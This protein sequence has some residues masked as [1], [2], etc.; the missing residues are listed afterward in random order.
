MAKHRDHKQQDGDFN[1]ISDKVVQY[2]SRIGAQG[3]TEVSAANLASLQKAHMMS[4]PYENYDIWASKPSS[5]AY[6]V[7]F[8]KIVVRRRGGYC[9]ELNGLFG[10][11]LRELGYEVEEYFGRWLKDE[12]LKIPA[13]RHRIL[14]VAVEGREFIVD[15]GVGQRTFLTPLE[16]VYD[17]VQNREGVDYRIVKNE[18]EESVVEFLADGKWIASYS[19]DSAPQYPIDFT[20]VHYFCSNEPSSVFRNNLFVHLPGADGRK[21]IAT[22]QDPETGLMTEKLSISAGEKSE[23]RFLRTEKDLKDALAT[24]FGIVV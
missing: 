24:H 20:Y 19:F 11:L 16:F 1:M 10:W 15:V 7:L 23:T 9:F 5:L 12:T 4:V 21:S 17:A 22:V 6:D 2:L 18:R 3:L 8:D 14:K 13:R